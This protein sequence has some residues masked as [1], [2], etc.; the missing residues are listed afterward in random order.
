MAGEA[1]GNDQHVVRH[2]ESKFFFD[3]DSISPANFM[4][5]RKEAEV[6]EYLSV[7]WFEIYAPGPRPDQIAAYRTVIHPNIR[8]FKTSDKLGVLNVG[9]TKETIRANTPDSRLLPFRHWPMPAPKED[10]GHAGIHNTADNET[11]V[12]ELIASTV[13]DVYPAR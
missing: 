10:A 2:C 6:E 7:G 8:K 12:A 1:I 4:L 3:D 5:R 13:I 9:K 11:R